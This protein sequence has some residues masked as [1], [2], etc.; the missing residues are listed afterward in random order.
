MD[1]CAKM[2]EQLKKLFKA[3]QRELDE[4]ISTE[5]IE[6]TVEDGNRHLMHSS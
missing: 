1:V 4:G 3:V 2:I 5:K 6:V